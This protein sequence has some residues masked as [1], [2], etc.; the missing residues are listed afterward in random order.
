MNICTVREST[1]SICVEK[2]FAIT[3]KHSSSERCTSTSSK[4]ETATPDS[5]IFKSGMLRKF[6]QVFKNVPRVTVPVKGK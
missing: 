4:T 3:I 6:S 2:Y 5:K 1:W